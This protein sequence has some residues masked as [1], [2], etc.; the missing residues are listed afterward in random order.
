[1][2]LHF[3]LTPYS[4]LLS[5]TVIDTTTESNLGGEGFISVYTAQFLLEGSQGRSL[6]EAET[7]QE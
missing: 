3:N 2:S 4:S 7:R 5:D 1:M 6:E